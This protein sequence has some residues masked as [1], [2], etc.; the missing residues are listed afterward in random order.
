MIFWRSSGDV[1]KKKL[2]IFDLDGTLFDTKDVNYHAYKAALNECGYDMSYD[3]YCNY[4]NG[5]HYTTF[6][7]A[8]LGEDNQIIQTVHNQKKRLYSKYLNKAVCNEHLF[9]LISA[10]REQYYT[11]I[12]TTASRQNVNDILE[13]AG[14]KESYFDLILTAEDFSRTKP[15]P[16][17]FLMAMERFG[18]SPEDTIIWEDSEVGLDAAKASGAYYVKVFGYN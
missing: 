4:C 2:A 10:M 9:R 8:I 14:E 17:G 7:A 15:D 12:V 11:A 5:R 3:Y 1:M 13:Y 18:V 16:E 6:L